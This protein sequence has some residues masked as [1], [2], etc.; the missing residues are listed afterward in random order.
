MVT[1][2]IPEQDMAYLNYVAEQNQVCLIGPGSPGVYSV[3]ES[4]AG[5]MPTKE[6]KKGKL[7][8]I[9]KSGTLTYELTRLLTNRG[10][11]Q[12]TV[13]GIG[14][15]FIAGTRF[16]ELL[17]LFEADPQTHQVLMQANAN[18]IGEV[19]AADM[20]SS[21]SKPVIVYMPELEPEVSDF[22][23]EGFKLQSKKMSYDVKY[24][25]LAKS[26]GIMVKKMSQIHTVLK[27]FGYK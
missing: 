22:H 15:D 24:N 16:K 8:L 17:Q 4:K 7:G 1:K 6:F 13:V 12:S 10:I 3:G 27:S 20:I 18:G 11:G 2:A 21:M 19:E 14:N 25:L 26:G 23:F 9:T 5:V